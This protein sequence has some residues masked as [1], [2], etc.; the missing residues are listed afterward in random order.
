MKNRFFNTFI[1]VLFLWLQFFSPIIEIYATD[2][3]TNAQEEDSCKKNLEDAQN[4]YFL[5]NFEKAIELAKQCV[6]K[7]S[8]TNTDRGNA[9]K[10]LAQA[11]WAL[12]D[13]SRAFTI[14]EQLL[15]LWP[16]YNPTIED[17]PPKFIELIAEVRASAPSRKPEKSKKWFLLGTGG[18]ILV[19]TA[20]ILLTAKK[21][22]GPPD[23][24]PR[25]PKWPD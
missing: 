2:T 22:N 5:G 9:Y 11:Y 25:P 10:I 23:P 6:Q 20:I 14:V 17:E 3:N 19:G 21:D 13:S 7:R 18:A 12:N 1:I 15:K 16:D 8:I 24:L 4:Q